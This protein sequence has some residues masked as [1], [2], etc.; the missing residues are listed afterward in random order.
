MNMHKQWRKHLLW[1]SSVLRPLVTQTQSRYFTTSRRRY[2]SAD[3][4]ACWM[5]S[6][7]QTDDVIKTLLLLSGFTSAICNVHLIF[8]LRIGESSF[9]SLEHLQEQRL[10]FLKT[11]FIKTK[12]KILWVMGCVVFLWLTSVKVSMEAKYLDHQSNMLSSSSSS[13]ISSPFFLFFFFPFPS[14]SFF[15]TGHM[16]HVV[17]D[18]LELLATT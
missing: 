12:R 18:A 4:D 10:F 11:G 5:I 15:N 14:S 2:F 3:T 7:F 13:S 16:K 9:L 6:N 8:L 17:G 1:F